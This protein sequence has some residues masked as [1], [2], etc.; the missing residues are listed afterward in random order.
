MA[1]DNVNL[2]SSTAASPNSSS[3]CTTQKKILSS[4]VLLFSQ[5]GAFLQKALQQMDEPRISQVR[6][7]TGSL[8]WHVYDPLSRRSV[9]LGSEAE[10]CTWLDQRFHS[11]F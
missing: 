4:I 2:S 1:F 11:A 7:R 3:H 6:T 9:V 10:V 5:A 8:L